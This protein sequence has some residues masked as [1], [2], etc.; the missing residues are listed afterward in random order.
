MKKLIY[1]IANSRFG[2]FLRNITGIRLPKFLISC[3]EEYLASD[4]F[5]WRTDN[6]LATIFNSTD[7]LE[8]FYG[9]SSI[10]KFVFYDRDGQY[11][12]EFDAN[13][14]NGISSLKITKEFM[15]E[16]S[17]GTFCVFNIPTEKTSQKLNITNRCYVGFGK[18][19]SFSMVHG[20]MIAKMVDPK[21]VKNHDVKSLVKPA[22]SDKKGN[23]SY[24]LQCSFDP[25]NKNELVFGNPLNKPI[26]IN[27]GK[28]SNTISAGGC[29]ILEL[30]IH[31]ADE[32]VVIESDFF[33][34]RPI[35][36]S[37]NDKYMDC[38]HG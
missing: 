6:N 16:S 8:Q 23:Y 11:L 4:L 7:L 13:F 2:C 37:S 18:D 29:A 15:R 22:M 10:L 34:P 9:I 32:V 36:I 19:E 35:V 30:N 25:K 14:Q 38:R 21:L 12:K 24:A 3:R 17:F 31:D 28:Q 33:W 27:I 26:E 20:N 1:K 5:V